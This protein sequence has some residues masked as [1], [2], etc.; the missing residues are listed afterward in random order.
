MNTP[1]L[2]IPVFELKLM[3]EGQEQPDWHVF[4]IRED[5]KE[6][7]TVTG[8]SDEHGNDVVSIEKD[9]KYFSVDENVQYLFIRLN[10]HLINNGD[11]ICE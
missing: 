6:L 7:W 1:V 4:E 10:E 9:L 8:I 11:E 5:A 3:F 2:D